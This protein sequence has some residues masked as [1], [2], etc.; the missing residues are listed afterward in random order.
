MKLSKNSTKKHVYTTHYN[1]HAC[2]GSK[3]V[4]ILSR[5]QHQFDFKSVFSRLNIFKTLHVY[6]SI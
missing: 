3:H 2:A 5:Q 4:D 6:C 1:S